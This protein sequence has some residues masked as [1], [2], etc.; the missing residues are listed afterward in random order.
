MYK[1]E[2]S[3]EIEAPIEYVFEFDSNPE[4][5]TKT[6]P[7]LR[8]LEIVEETEE[9]VRMSAVYEMLGQSIDIEEEL[10]I[11][12]PHEHYHVTVEGDGVSG[13]INNHFEGTESGTRINHSAEFDFGDSL[14]DR[15]MAPVV[16][17]YNER[18]FKNH[19]QH[20][21][22][23]IEAEIEADSE[24]EHEARTERGRTRGQN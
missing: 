22:E 19:L 15:L 12:E 4:N 20:M 14:F 2:H 16:R 3:V 8:D 17:R 7:G 18:Q 5:W 10:T 24:A 9:T 6:M 1:F 11:V 21:K 13:E 23:L